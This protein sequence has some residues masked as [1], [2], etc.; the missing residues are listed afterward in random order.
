MTNKTSRTPIEPIYRQIVPT[1][2]EKLA[3]FYLCIHELWD[4]DAEYEHAW[5]SGASPEEQT[6][7]LAAIETANVQFRA[8]DEAVTRVKR[9]ESH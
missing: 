3:R 1:T 4:V 8:A 6:R 9:N 7:L 2:F 5:A